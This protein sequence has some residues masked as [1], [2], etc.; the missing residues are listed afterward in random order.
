[1]A[2]VLGGVSAVTQQRHE[3][4]GGG[5]GGEEPAKTEG[6]QERMGGVLTAIFRYG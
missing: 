3:P 5:G 6:R 2:R 4:G 1:M